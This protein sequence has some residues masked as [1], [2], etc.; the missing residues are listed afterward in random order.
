M[1]D[2]SSTE[3]SEF[4]SLQIIFKNIDLVFDKEGVINKDI[5]DKNL[6]I[7][8]RLRKSRARYLNSLRL[9]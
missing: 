4:I 3:R 6:I 8:K 1:G 5:E 9:L 7:V 2:L